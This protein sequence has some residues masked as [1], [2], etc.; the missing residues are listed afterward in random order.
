[1]YEKKYMERAEYLAEQYSE[2]PNTKVG[3]AIENNNCLIA[4]GWNNMPERSNIKFPWAREGATLK[5]KYPFVVHAEMRAI[6]SCCQSLHNSTV[7]VTL[8]PCSN[9]AKLI[10]QSGVKKVYYKDDKYK[11]TEDVKAA[12]MLF[13]ACGVN[14]EQSPE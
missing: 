8:F 6:T 9:C 12:K 2:D 4:T 7:Y 5:T 10:V 1:M 11:D 13:D 3:C 14:Y